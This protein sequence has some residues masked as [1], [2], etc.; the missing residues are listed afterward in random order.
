[1]PNLL[2]MKHS[3][4]ENLLD[5]GLKLVKTTRSTSGF[6]Q[7]EDKSLAVPLGYDASKVDSE[8]KVNLPPELKQRIER[9]TVTCHKNNVAR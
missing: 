6:G 1:M 7:E 4:K 2:P 9:K 5:P 3:L 8:C